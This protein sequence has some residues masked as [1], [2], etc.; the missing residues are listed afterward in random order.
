MEIDRD[1][2]E[3]MPVPKAILKSAVPAIVGMIV[4]L[5]YNIADTYF[6]GQTGNPLQV[7]AVSLTLP[8]FLLFMAT[9]NLLGI[10]G[11]S[12]IS[13]SLGAGN[14]G[15][16]KKVSSFCFYSSILLG[17]IFTFLFWILMPQI[18]RMIGTSSDTIGYARDYLNIVAPSAPFVIISTAFGNILRAEGRSRQAMM[19]MLLGTITNIILDPIMI[20][21]LNM[22]VSGAALATLIGNIVG[23]F[24]Y[25]I[26][27]KKSRTLLS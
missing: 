27:I 15:Y 10:G 18:L 22:G 26:Y 14:A 3:R 7:A 20:L 16:A 24:Y 2:F 17:V 4:I 19:G 1:I 5:V 11:T 12:V 8:V 9:G 13:R 23:A 21:A 6:V 25:I